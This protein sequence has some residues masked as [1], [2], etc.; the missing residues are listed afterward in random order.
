MGLFFVPVA[1]VVFG[2]VS[3]AEQGVASGTNNSFRELGGT[4][5]VAVLG[6]VFSAAGSFGSKAAFVDGLRPALLVGT[7]VL[8]LGA[9]AATAHSR[10]APDGRSIPEQEGAELAP[11]LV[12]V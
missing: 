7:I 11:E 8:G 12:T 4:M 6:S 1:T 9:V 2:S 3:V 10:P 5:G